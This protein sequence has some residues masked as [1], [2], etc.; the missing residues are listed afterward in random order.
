[1]RPAGRPAA[2]VPVR[3][4]LIVCT[5][6][7]DLDEYRP[8][9]VLNC[10]GLTGRPNIDWCE[11]H[12]IETVRVNVM[13]TLILADACFRRG[14]HMT[15][16]ATG[17]IYNYDDGEHRC[18]GGRPFTET[19]PPNY[20]GSFYSITKA[21]AERL[22][23]PYPNILTLRIRMPITDDLHPR[24]FITKITHYAK[25][26]NYPNSVTVLTDM[27]PV[28]I[29]MTERELKGIY[30]FTNPGTITHNGLLQLYKEYI[31]PNFKWEN[32]TLEEQ[33]KVLKSGRCNCHLD[34]SKLLKEFPDIP[35]IHT[36]I[37]GVYTRMKAS[38]GQ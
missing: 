36:S 6:T 13:G 35:D 4:A 12:K 3:A 15:N 11:E 32:F 27:L 34:V 37:R 8:K 2:A 29:R 9:Y 25:L 23:A 18:D 7:S 26:I 19:D 22:L 14:I 30:N 20:T 17:C 28:S 31:D 1:M 24:N 10:A 21:M 16:Y 5:R 38:L 33:A